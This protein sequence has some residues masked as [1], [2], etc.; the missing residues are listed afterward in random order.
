[1]SRS[2][3]CDNPYADNGGND[4]EGNQME[5]LGLVVNLNI[6]IKYSMANH[7][8]PTQCLSVE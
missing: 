4:C 1:M 5:D 6:E 2:R 7:V 3:S 8:L